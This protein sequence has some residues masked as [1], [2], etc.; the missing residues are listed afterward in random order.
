MGSFLPSYKMWHFL[1]E[2]VTPKQFWCR[3]AK[4]RRFLWRRCVKMAR[5]FTL[6]LWFGQ[7]WSPTIL[8][9]DTAAAMKLP[10]WFGQHG[11]HPGVRH[12]CCNK[13]D[14]V[15]PQSIGHTNSLVQVLLAS[16]SSCSQT[17]AIEGIKNNVENRTRSAMTTTQSGHGSGLEP[18]HSKKKLEANVL[19]A[20]ND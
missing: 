12:C 18:S 15:I 3:I 20:E 14:W 1:R 17:M 5:T 16:P 8:V 4:K 9:C 7:H 13:T 2:G 10:L 6:S 19:R 11:H